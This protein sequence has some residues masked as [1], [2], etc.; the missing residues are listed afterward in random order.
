[1]NLKLIAA[2]GV[3]LAIIGAYALGRH[4]GKKMC[5]GSAAVT[6][7]EGVKN[8]AKIEKQINRMDESA[9]DRALSHWVR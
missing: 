8:D 2:I 7:Q 6:Y 5:V 3:L 4:D 1:M 9:I